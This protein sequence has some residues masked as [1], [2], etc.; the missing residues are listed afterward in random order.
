MTMKTKPKLLAG[1]KNI[2][3]YRHS[4]L[5]A[6]ISYLSFRVC[7][8]KYSYT[9]ITSLIWFSY[10]SHIILLPCLRFSQ[11]SVTMAQPVS[12]WTRPASHPSQVCSRPLLPRSTPSH[13]TLWAP[14]C[15]SKTSKLLLTEGQRAGVPD[16]RFTCQA[17]SHIISSRYALL[18]LRSDLPTPCLLSFFLQCTYFPFSWHSA[19]SEV[20]LT[21]VIF[22]L[23]NW[24]KNF[25]KARTWVRVFLC[26]P[27]IWNRAWHMW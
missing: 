22:C 18:P 7:I 12:M 21:L 6:V 5:I 27:S 9:R 4:S 8:C 10:T 24:S 17:P 3:S 19:P 23:P 26:S 16:V 20:I 15:A 14:I 2:A 1:A 25:R 13:L 11:G